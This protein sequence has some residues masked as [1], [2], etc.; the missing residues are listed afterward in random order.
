MRRLI[1]ELIYEF[2]KYERDFNREEVVRIIYNEAKLSY[3][4]VTK[5]KV[6]EMVERYL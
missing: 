3:P 6:Q 4:R 2:K 5:S 1:R